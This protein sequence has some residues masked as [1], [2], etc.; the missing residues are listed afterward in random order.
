[1]IKWHRN[2]ISELESKG[3]QIIGTTNGKKH[4][5]LLFL[6][7]VGHQRFYVI[8][9]GNSPGCFRNVKNLVKDVLRMVEDPNHD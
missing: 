2:V 6:D 7:K 9:R 3:V 1:M 8:S 5:R 4:T